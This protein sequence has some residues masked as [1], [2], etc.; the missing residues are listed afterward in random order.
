MRI[1]KIALVAVFILASQPVAAFD[2]FGPKHTPKPITDFILAGRHV[3]MLAVT[4]LARADT[5]IRRAR[6]EE[7]LTMAKV[8]PGY[9]QPALVSVDLRVPF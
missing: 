5:A 6:L 8:M 3:E 2:D 4:R 9:P 7:S 1:R